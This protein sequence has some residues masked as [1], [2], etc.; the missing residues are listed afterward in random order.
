MAVLP[1][2]SFVR[3]YNRYSILNTI[4][5]SG[6]ISRIDISKT[7]GLSRASVTGITA[8]LMDEGLIVEK[9]TGAYAGGRRP[10]LL[11]LNPDGAYVLGVNVALNQISVAVVDFLARCKV[12]H[13]APL[14]A[15]CY[16]PEALAEKIAQ[17]IQACMWKSSFS[18]DRI[19]GVG[20][21]LPGLVDSEAGLVRYIPHYEWIDLDFRDILEKKIGHKIFIDNDT[22]NLAIAEHWF[23]LARDSE[24]FITIAIETGIGAGCVVN[25]QLMR[26]DSGMASEFGHMIID[27][28]GPLCR[29]GRRGCLGTYAGIGAVMRDAAALMEKGVL[30]KKV[31]N[32]VTFEDVLG[33]IEA[34]Y[35]EILEI[36]DR[37]G[38]ALGWGISHLI[39][40]FNPEK[41]II[42]GRGVQAGDAL[43]KPMFESI[44]KNQPD[45]L[46][47]FNAEIII[48]SWTEEDW[49]VGA[50]T[51]ALQ[52][53]Y[54]SPTS[55]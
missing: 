40:M 47:C 11:S 37:A 42:T 13:T 27:S 10:V 3:A 12:F 31:G 28:D 17:A 55:R 45:T 51:L 22:N 16:T 26:G 43:F 35:R 33:W 4:R 29:C 46:G 52:E 18:R 53:I 30:K 15:D 50:G 6:M 34:G 41:I 9:E 23:G 24:N 7:T 1:V 38:R 5:S 36:Y 54:K 39:K 32:E 2:R 25:G 19:S 14:E 20:V 48:K 49:V 21:G 8:E 44:E